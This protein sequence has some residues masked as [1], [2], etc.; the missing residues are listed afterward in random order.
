MIKGGSEK[1]KWREVTRIKSS[2]L[3]YIQLATDFT[4]LWVSDSMLKFLR[5]S[6]SDIIGK[7]WFNH[8]P[9]EEH[10]QVLQIL[11][12]RQATKMPGFSMRHIYKPVLYGKRRKVLVRWLTEPI[13]DDSGRII[14]YRVIGKPEK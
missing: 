8:I 1:L 14:E 10:E 13:L 12:L 5:C 6:A 9:K 11:R 4:L 2:G 7:S 3:F